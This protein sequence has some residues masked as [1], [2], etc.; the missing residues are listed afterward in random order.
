MP[1]IQEQGLWF[2]FRLRKKFSLKDFLL[3]NPNLNYEDIKD[4]FYNNKV[5][6]PDELQYS[7]LKEEIKK[8]SEAN[9]EKQKKQTAEKTSQSK[10][11]EVKKSP[12]R[13]RR[14]R[15]TSAN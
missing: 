15:K 3:K 10:T 7:L 11:K 1:E 14:K 4:F 6:P 9:K 13:R 2:I 5:Q 12:P 8:E